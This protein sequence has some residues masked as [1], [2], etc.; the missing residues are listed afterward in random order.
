MRKIIAYL[1]IALFL[2]SA[3][4]AQPASPALTSA[5]ER[6]AVTANNMVSAQKISAETPEECLE[7][8]SNLYPDSSEESLKERCAIKITNAERL[9]AVEARRIQKEEE[10]KNTQNNTNLIK[11]K[12]ANAFKARIIA[13]DK[14]TQARK[15]YLAVKERYQTARQNYIAAQNGFKEAKI[16]FKECEG[17]ETAECSQWREE[18]KERAREFLLKTSDNILGY[19]NKIKANVESNEDLTEEEA[20]EI[21]KDIGKMISEI[22]G[23]K[24]TIGSSEDK[25]EIIGASKTIK[26]AWLRAK[27]RLLIYTGRIVNARIGGIIVK[28]KQLEVKLEKIMERMEEKGIG[29][30]EIQTLVDQFNEKIDEAKTNYESALDKFK[31]AASSEDVETA[32]ELAVEGH[33]YMKAAHKALQEAQKLLRDIILSI[34][35]AGGQEELTAVAGEEE[36]SA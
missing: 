11:Y 20:S 2:I 23:A 17:E 7:R 19:L 9:R 27:K 30:S 32:H 3:V 4:P 36:A 35:Q 10:L 28:T 34:K 13:Q 12:E 31:E 5:R 26:Q 14:L 16:R 25:D 22:E 24:S 8:L 18:I 33:N 6:K 15:N 1:I 29:T 21:L